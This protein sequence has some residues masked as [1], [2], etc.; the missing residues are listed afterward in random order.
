M[1]LAM[2]KILA[3]YSTCDTFSLTG[4]ALEYN[5]TEEE[6]LNALKKTEEMTKE[7]KR[8]QF[9]NKRAEFLNY[10]S[11]D[12]MYEEIKQEC[13]DFYN[14][15]NR[16]KYIKKHFDS[17]NIEMYK[18]LGFTD[19][20]IEEIKN[21]FFHCSFIADDVGDKTKYGKE[22]NGFFC[23]LYR[24]IAMNIDRE[25][26]KTKYILNNGKSPLEQIPKELKEHFLYYEVSYFNSVTISSRLMINY[27]FRLN[28]ETKKYL[29][30]FRNDF[31]LND[32]EDL[33]LYKDNEIIFSSCTNEGYNSIDFDYKTMSDDEILDFINDEYYEKDNSKI[34]EVVNKL[35]RMEVKDKFSFKN[36]NIEDKKIMEKICSI[37][38]KINLKLFS[39]D[40]KKCNFGMVNQDGNFSEIEDLPAILCNVEDIIEK[41]R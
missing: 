33:T 5:I 22:N 12:E 40:N 9:E 19:E 18:K 14:E 27:Y 35:I 26:E 11:F 8:K 28:D 37:C 2:K 4:G 25:K 23:N 38:D 21:N 13:Y 6:F 17:K 3:K 24:E 1:G 41:K 30:Q 15:Q 39:R 32:L 10:P 29:L 7:E 16:E 20:K 34:I 36:F 31:E